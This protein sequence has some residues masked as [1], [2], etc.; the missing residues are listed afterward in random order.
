[1]NN[2]GTGLEVLHESPMSITDWINKT[3]GAVSLQHIKSVITVTEIVGN[4]IITHSMV[5]NL[6]GHSTLWCKFL[7]NSNWYAV[8]GKGLITSM[9]RFGKV[10]MIDTE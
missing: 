7:S 8:D 10:H 6:F 5:S 3:I 2:T 9:D 4:N 1:M